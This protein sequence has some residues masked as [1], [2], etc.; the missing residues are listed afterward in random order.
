M[1]I[2]IQKKESNY[3]E[4]PRELINDKRLHFKDLGAMVSILAEPTRLTIERMAQ[5]NPDGFVRLLNLG[6]LERA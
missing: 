6:Y 3:I 1:I 2:R 4:I 5:S